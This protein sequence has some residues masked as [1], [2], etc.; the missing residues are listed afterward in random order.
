MLLLFLSRQFGVIVCVGLALLL[1]LG[2]FD[3]DVTDTGD[4]PGMLMPDGA[5]V[6]LAAALHGDMERKDEVTSAMPP[7]QPTPPA[8]LVYE[9]TLPLGVSPAPLI[10]DEEEAWNDT[11]RGPV[12]LLL[13]AALAPCSSPSSSSQTM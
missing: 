2:L 11:C 8:P 1:V 10:A 9:P 6:N 3:V 4:Q 5:S 13:H 12:A 7:Q